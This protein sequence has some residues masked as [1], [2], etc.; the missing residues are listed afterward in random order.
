M[1]I[2]QTPV[3]FGNSGTVGPIETEIR[4][5]IFQTLRELGRS[6]GE[7]RISFKNTPESVVV[8][9]ENMQSIIDG[10]D[11][12]QAIQNSREFDSET[13]TY[14][15]HRVFIS[16]SGRDPEADHVLPLGLYPHAGND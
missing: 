11:I 4:Q 15:G 14:R 12:S 3:K 8:N 10:I 5:I 7:V 2:L 16:Y 9:I 13:R 1:K 6:P